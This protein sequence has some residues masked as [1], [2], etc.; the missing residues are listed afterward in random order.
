M[1]SRRKLLPLT[2][3]LALACANPL[4]LNNRSQFVVADVGETVDVTLGNAG[5]ATYESPPGI[6]SDVLTFLSVDVVPPNNPG[7]PNQRF[8]FKAETRGVAIVTFRRTL[9][10]DLVSVVVDTI[11][12][13]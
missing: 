7:G 6:S 1:L 11:M 13:R 10:Q 2:A 8:R 12:V 4:D 9:D 3:S 5:P